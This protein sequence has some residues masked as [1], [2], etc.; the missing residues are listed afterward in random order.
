MSTRMNPLRFVP[1]HV[2]DLL[3]SGEELTLPRT[4]C[5][6]DG[7]V[8]IIDIA[9]YSTL[10]S[11]LAE[12]YGA[13]AGGAKIQSLLNPPFERIIE[14]VHRFN[15]SIIKFAGDA[16]IVCWNYGFRRSNSS[17]GGNHHQVD[18]TDAI[19]CCS[20]LLIL[21]SDYRI[22][23]GEGVLAAVGQ[24][25]HNQGNISEELTRPLGIGQ[26]QQQ[27]QL[28][29]D[30]ELPAPPPPPP[31]LQFLDTFNP[32]MLTHS[33]GSSTSTASTS[34]TTV[35]S[36][37]NNPASGRLAPITPTSKLTSPP[38]GQN[39]LS[40]IPS[41]RHMSFAASTPSSFA[42]SLSNNANTGNRR[43][44]LEEPAGLGGLAAITTR[45]SFS[46]GTGTSVGVGGAGSNFISGNFRTTSQLDRSRLSTVPLQIHI[47]LAMGETNHVLLGCAD[48]FVLDVVASSNENNGGNNGAPRIETTTT[49]TTTDPF[50]SGRIEYF[51][52]G[53]AVVEAGELFGHVSPGELVVSRQCWKA[54]IEAIEL[55][56]VNKSEVDRWDFSGKL[57]YNLSRED[58]L[59]TSSREDLISL[60][61]FS[62]NSNV[63]GGGIGMGKGGKYQIGLKSGDG[64]V[65]GQT[66]QSLFAFT[67]LLKRVTNGLRRS[68]GH[69]K[70]GSDELDQNSSVELVNPS[71]HFIDMG[72]G[73]EGGLSNLG[74]TPYKIF[75]RSLLFIEES[76][77]RHI[78]SSVLSHYNG[79]KGFKPVSM[80]SLTHEDNVD[81]KDSE[82]VDTA[83]DVANTLDYN[84]LRKIT[85]VFLRFPSFT[86]STFFSRGPTLLKAQGVF[87]LALAVARDHGGTCRQ[88]GCDDKAATL[89]LVWGMEGFA[90]ERG[91]AVH[92]CTAAMEMQEG[93]RRLI[94]DDFSIGISTGS[95]FAG[96]IGNNHRSDG[97]VLG[98]CVNTAARI[99][100]HPICQGKVLCEITTAS[101]CPSDIVFDEG[102]EITVKGAPA[103]IKVHTPLRLRRMTDSMM[104]LE[105]A[106]F[107]AGRKVELEKLQDVIDGWTREPVL[108]ARVIFT[109]GT[110]YGKS[111]LASW[112][113]FHAGKVP[114][115]LRWF[116]FY[117]LHCYCL[118]RHSGVQFTP[119][120]SIIRTS[121]A[122]RGNETNRRSMYSPFV[123]V[124]ETI[125][126]E[127]YSKFIETGRLKEMFDS[128]PHLPSLKVK[129][130]NV[131][132]R[133]S[134][135]SSA[136]RSSSTT[137]VINRS[138]A[139]IA[140]GTPEIHIEGTPAAPASKFADSMAS[141]RS[142]TARGPKRS[143][144]V[145]SMR[146]RFM[147]KV[148]INRSGTPNSKD[149]SGGDDDGNDEEADRVGND[150]GKKI[151]IYRKPSTRESKP[152]TQSIG[153][154]KQE[155]LSKRGT[156]KGP[157]TSG[158]NTPTIR[159]KIGLLSVTPSPFSLTKRRKSSFST[160]QATIIASFVSS[161]PTASNQSPV[162]RSRAGSVFINRSPSFSS[163]ASSPIMTPIGRGGADT[164]PFGS[165]Q[166]MTD[167]ETTQTS[168]DN[169]SLNESELGSM[170]F[171]RYSKTMSATDVMT[172]QGRIAEALTILLGEDSADKRV[173]ELAFPSIKAV[174]PFA[175]QSQT[176]VVDGKRVNVSSQALGGPKVEIVGGKPMS[177]GVDMIDFENRVAT[178]VTRLLNIIS[179]INV[180]IFMSLDD[181]QWMD[182]N[183]LD[184]TAEI[185]R[186][187][188]KVFC[189]LQSRPPEEYDPALKHMYTRILEIQ[190]VKHINLGPLDINGIEE[191]LQNVMWDRLKGEIRVSDNLVRE[192]LAQS[193]GIPFVATVISQILNDEG[194]LIMRA[195]FL[196][197][198]RVQGGGDIGNK[199]GQILP[200]DAI[201]AVVAQFDKLNPE[202]KAI[203]R[204][205]AVAGQHFSLQ[206]IS[207]VLPLYAHGAVFESTHPD[208]LLKI[209]KESDPYH[210][211][212]LTEAN[213]NA[214]ATLPTSATVRNTS[215][216]ALANSRMMIDPTTISEAAASELR[217]SHYLIQQGVLSTILPQKKEILHKLFVDMY[218]ARM[219]DP[220]KPATYQEVG[221]NSA[222]L[223]GG[224]SKV[225]DSRLTIDKAGVI[226][227]RTTSRRQQRSAHV[228]ESLLHHLL[229]IPGDSRRK[230][231]YFTLAFEQCAEMGRTVDG[232]WFYEKMQQLSKE[233][234]R[235]ALTLLDMSFESRINRRGKHLRLLAQ[236]HQQTG[237]YSAAI[238][239][240]DEALKLYGFNKLPD[241][242]TTGSKLLLLAFLL[243][244]NRRTWSCTDEDQVIESQK[245]CM[246]LFP[247]AFQ[248]FDDQ[249]GR[250]SFLGKFFKKRTRNKIGVSG[251]K[252][253]Q[254]FSFDEVL[255]EINE[256][257][258]LSI[259]SRI[260][261]KRISHLDVAVYGLMS[262]S[263]TLGMAK[264]QGARPL[265]NSARMALVA[266]TVWG[267]TL[268]DLYIQRY[269][270]NRRRL[271]F[272]EHTHHGSSTNNNPGPG[273]E[274]T[275]TVEGHQFGRVSDIDRLLIIE[276]HHSLQYTMVLRSDFAAA[277]EHAI[278]HAAGM[279]ATGHLGTEF[280]ISAAYWSTMLL[281]T[282]GQVA[283][284]LDVG[285]NV[286]EA[287]MQKTNYAITCDALL[288]FAMC[289]SLSGNLVDAE[290]HYQAALKGFNASENSPEFRQIGSV[291][292]KL[293][294][295]V[296]KVQTSEPTESVQWRRL[297]AATGTMLEQTLVDI[298]KM[299][300][301]SISPG[302]VRIVWVLLEW[303]S[304]SRELPTPDPTWTQTDTN[305]EI[306]AIQNLLRAV[307]V[308]IKSSF[309][310]INPLMRFLRKLLKAGEFLL[311]EE[312]DMCLSLIK[313]AI[314]EASIFPFMTI[315]I[316]A[317]TLVRMF[318]IRKHC[319]GGWLT[320][321]S[322][323]GS[324]AND[325]KMADEVPSTTSMGGMEQA[326]TLEE[327]KTFF[328]A[329]GASWE[330]AQ[331]DS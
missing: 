196:D 281:T 92:A 241:D 238:E 312:T 23:L 275:V 82:A 68:G 116:V 8:A 107:I 98:V 260:H 250:L 83:R 254:A 249:H 308:L 297:V 122:G 208:F 244:F 152:T 73:G 45:H 164:N 167:R 134:H 99:M 310:R 120:P 191:L 127:F 43:S 161:I 253:G 160:I 30:Q 207:T 31:S 170:V 239:S 81:D 74:S 240:S 172:P 1:Q 77:A 276:S 331:L 150:D 51:I 330:L 189:M 296:I 110:G 113:E 217:F 318:R 50:T 237:N 76:L 192:V 129:P 86:E 211:I 49:T 17:S 115:V 34:I 265:R 80:M 22:S 311:G 10:T 95:V 158:S 222:G 317:T 243:Q 229:Q 66:E 121:S 29:Q 263:L 65:V 215:N 103:P 248:A 293:V 174:S 173:L 140:D 223:G 326:I 128:K 40:T 147:E 283:D 295:E 130:A 100:C 104:Y 57:R 26:Q 142:M 181:L 287:A 212:S 209:I 210:F 274:N 256:T 298:A 124:I 6:K 272:G 13:E 216:S 306:Q 242:T 183:S 201:T 75:E 37:S 178:V 91:E 60:S 230:L 52:S 94:G 314:Q 278:M 54:M 89:L 228:L 277:A 188:P 322:T 233:N 61:N 232:F 9:G 301:L 313:N 159:G 59:S 144:T 151:K 88:F 48:P 204:V 259:V 138:L 193:Q 62:T 290:K 202:M 78:H 119:L 236:L 90:H 227:A 185:L 70:V 39:M 261:L 282:L 101:G 105:A 262:T 234:N 300:L 156:V 305:T 135:T 187:C 226:V 133:A 102:T 155:T 200:T 123:N 44:Y 190:S 5:V 46:V 112:V 32:G 146:S 63:G 143:G 2:R 25:A 252:P 67:D 85:A 24:Q 114:N 280:N 18:V 11:R 20:E 303:I 220:D 125:L 206:D 69:G 184:L 247:K 71:T 269:H 33:R 169:I 273:H 307:D 270:R 171:K 53:R 257:F 180:K 214:S 255:R 182:S 299:V 7:I 177:G 41:T 225:N 266:E 72:I 176:V 289:L 323:N 16:V 325:D 292:C 320:Y 79:G 153:S 118:P 194:D 324:S 203:L 195:G 163:L 148:E 42:N 166:S 117:F 36:G 15:G 218:D 84:Q 291:C 315:G 137:P 245:L 14:V 198:R 93:I 131:R 246:E 309:T 126:L 136:Y 279:S 154:G 329:N 28:Q 285:G 96:I 106:P 213:L 47:G 231:K 271:L 55:G 4:D 284:G 3:R 251:N 87:Q 304:L 179:A 58:L 97:T 267:T 288:L 157:R 268:S 109:S 224:S 27:Q 235:E 286:C 35:T 258:E 319:G 162:A 64:I 197:R 56:I 168:K 141:L 132:R 221:Y 108:P 302:I 19:A 149:S 205:A 316:K 145:K 38:T 12:I 264:F 175:G 199:S 219:S 186:R 294:F 321:Q 21:F 328:Q 139:A 165:L 327:A 111:S